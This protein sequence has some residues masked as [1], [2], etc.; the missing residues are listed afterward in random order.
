MSQTSPSYTDKLFQ[1]L[2]QLHDTLDRHGIWHSLLFGTLLG[3]VRDGELI[4]WDHDLDLLIHRADIDRVVALN[5]ELAPLGLSFWSGRT[6][7]DRLALNPGRVP[8]FDPGYLGIMVGDVCRGE[9][10]APTLFSDGVLRLYDLE[11]EVA[12]WPHSSFPAFV[13]EDLTTADVHGV[14][15]PVPAH[16]EQLLAWHYGDDWRTPYQAPLDGG[17]GR[18]GRTAHGDVPLPQLA[19]RI[20]WCEAEGWDRSVYAAEPAWPRRLNGAGPSEDS[21]PRTATTS[22]SAWWHSLD[23]ISRFY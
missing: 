10:Y 18:E 17:R 4:P 16:A 14:P 21:L 9:V 1:L 22:R 6:L 5:E 3:A 19:E 12:F 11:H 20:A 13:V 7:A 15:L 8:W 23:E 2:V